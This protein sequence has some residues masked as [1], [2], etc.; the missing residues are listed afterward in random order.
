MEDIYN[1]AK[2]ALM[3]AEEDTTEHFIR[4]SKTTHTPPFSQNLQLARRIKNAMEE[5]RFVPF[6]QGIINNQSK[7]FEQFECL[8]RLKENNNFLQPI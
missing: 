5:H 8:V 6:F 2:L 4:Y 7:E 3:L 1:Q